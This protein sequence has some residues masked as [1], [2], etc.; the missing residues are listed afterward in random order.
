ML[1]FVFFLV[2]NKTVLQ[3][4][5]LSEES[6]IPALHCNI[7]LLNTYTVPLSSGDM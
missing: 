2:K 5:D 7:Q 1:F 3:C 6:P 4:T